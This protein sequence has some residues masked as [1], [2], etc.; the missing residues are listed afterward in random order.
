MTSP[1]PVVRLCSDHFTA[2]T[3]L[4]EFLSLPNRQQNGLQPV[5]E[6][7][8]GAHNLLDGPTRRTRIESS[9]SYQVWDPRESLV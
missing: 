3:P 8:E 1:S 2:H 5:R 9:S 7:R 6:G 4:L